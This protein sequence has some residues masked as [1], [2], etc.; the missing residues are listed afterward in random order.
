MELTREQVNEVFAKGTD[1][2]NILLA[3]HELVIPNW[4]NVT[5][6]NGHPQ[7]GKELWLFIARSFMDYDA[8]H[9]KSVL[10]GGLW[11]DKGFSTGKKLGDWEVSIADL[12]LKY[13]EDA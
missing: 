2:V 4:H 12:R 3:L 8:Q 6:V 7:A 9:H 11:M 5:K 13:K 10:P 1:Q